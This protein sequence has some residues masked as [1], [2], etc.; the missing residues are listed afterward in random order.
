MVDESV[1]QLATEY[2]DRYLED[3]KGANLV[4]MLWYVDAREKLVPEL[5]EVNEALA[6]RPSAR[7]HRVEGKVIF[8]ATDGER[9]ILQSD[10]DQGYSDYTAEIRKL[11][12]RLR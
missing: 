12:E 2:L 8:T 6:R 4:G 1:V 7:V 9:T 10:W 11:S 5:D 3:E